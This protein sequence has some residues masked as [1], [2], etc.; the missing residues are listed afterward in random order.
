LSKFDRRRLTN[1]A[2]AAAASGTLANRR[3]LNISRTARSS[4]ADNPSAR[5][6]VESA[7]RI[8][9][10]MT[11][12]RST[13]PKSRSAS[14]LPALLGKPLH[15]VSG[16]RLVHRYSTDVECV[17]RRDGLIPGELSSDDSAFELLV[18]LLVADR[19]LDDE[20]LR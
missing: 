12:A 7:S 5:S 18:Q 20:Q 6:T 2:P 11:L 19:R 3:T 15:H 16:A 17:H 4:R 14:R 9:K 13:A 10:P 1:T 8:S